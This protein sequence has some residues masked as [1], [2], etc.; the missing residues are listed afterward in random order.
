MHQLYTGL[1]PPELYA[2][3]HEARFIQRFLKLAE[4]PKIN[5]DEFYDFCGF[6]CDSF[7]HQS[8]PR[9]QAPTPAALENSVPTVNSTADHDHDQQHRKSKRRRKT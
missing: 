5:D 2:Y 3:D 4:N 9:L 7:L 1:R 8:N 6:C